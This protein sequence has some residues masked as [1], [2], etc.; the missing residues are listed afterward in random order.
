M[1]GRRGR[2]TEF[3]SACR[4]LESYFGHGVRDCAGALSQ[5]ASGRKLREIVH[6]LHRPATA[7]PAQ[8][9]FPALSRIPQCID[10]ADPMGPR[11]TPGRRNPPAG[12][13]DTHPY[14]YSGRAHRRPG[15]PAVVGSLSGHARETVHPA[16][17][18]MLPAPGNM[19]TARVT[20]HAASPSLRRAHD[21]GTQRLEVPLSMPEIASAFR[22]RSVGRSRSASTWW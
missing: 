9:P 14:G 20:Q 8:R 10:H 17:I 3:R 6:P 18:T 15:D 16:T 4:V 11:D 21:P 12:G 1:F 5:G 19:L 7:A 2:A 22:A 13:A